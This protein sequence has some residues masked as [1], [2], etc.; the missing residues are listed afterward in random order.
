MAGADRAER[1]QPRRL[2]APCAHDRADGGVTHPPDP[3]PRPTLALYAALW[4]LG[5]IPKESIQ[6]LV[7][8]VTDKA[9]ACLF[10][11]SIAMQL[12]SLS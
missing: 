9:D 11:S 8:T 5:S 10:G 4:V 12:E 2:S 1:L 6:L 7:M 3:A